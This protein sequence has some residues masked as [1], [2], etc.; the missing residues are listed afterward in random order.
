GHRD[1]PAVA[2][3]SDD[4]TD[5]QYVGQFLPTLVDVK[6]EVAVALRQVRH[7]KLG[8]CVGSAE[9]GAQEARLGPGVV[10]PPEPDAA[11]KTRPHGAEPDIPHAAFE[12]LPA[13]Q[14]PRVEDGGT[15]QH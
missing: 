7:T 12:W 11:V 15:S 8:G 2:R 14:P 9:Y 1:G 4:L 5:P 10:A 3:P 13:R 6:A